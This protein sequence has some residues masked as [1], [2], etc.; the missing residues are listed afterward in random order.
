MRPGQLILDTG[1]ELDEAEGS[2]LDGEVEELEE[3]MELIPADDGEELGG[4]VDTEHAQWTRCDST[5]VAPAASTNSAI[6]KEPEVAGESILPVDN[7]HDPGTN[8]QLALNR[9]ASCGNTT[10]VEPLLAAGARADVGDSNG[11]T[12]ILQAAWAG[13][14]AG[15]STHDER[16]SEGATCLLNAAYNGHNQALELLLLRGASITDSDKSG[17][18]APKKAAFNGHADTLAALH[19]QGADLRKRNRDGDTALSLAASQGHLNRVMFLL[20]QGVDIDQ[21]SFDGYTPLLKAA[22]NGHTEVARFLLSRGA[23]TETEVDAGDIISVAKG[24]E[25]YAMAEELRTHLRTIEIQRRQQRIGLRSSRR[26]AR[27]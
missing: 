8:V 7:I 21:G 17:S 18:T 22:A 9:A 2:I 24:N 23:D 4:G 6:G 10:L 5:T 26:L 11:N 3:G 15:N 27:E 13:Q 19:G 1:E 20:H 12:A 16:D 14:T 25:H